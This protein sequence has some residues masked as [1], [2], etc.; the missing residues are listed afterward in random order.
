[1]S[2]L[3]L[4]KALQ[5]SAFARFIG[6]LDHLFCAALELGHIAGMLLLLTSILLTTL[7]LLGLGL[8]QVPIAQLQEATGKLF[9][10]GLALL[11]VSGLLIFLPAATSYYPN[12][13]FWAKFVLLGIALLVYL[14]L[15]RKVAST[16]SPNRLLAKAT[17]SLLLS[18]WL[19]VAFAGRFIGFL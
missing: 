9:W 10:S 7:N 11:V 13:F 5:A 6:G 15:Y 14:T 2:A 16:S 18:L 4:F 12:D 1:M 8:S 17:G 19:G 3:E